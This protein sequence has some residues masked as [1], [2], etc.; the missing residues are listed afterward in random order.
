MSNAKD[1]NW[2]IAFSDKTTGI[3]SVPQCLT[4]GD[5]FGDGSNRILI[6]SLDQKLI[7]FE[8]SRIAHEIPLPDMPS[9]ICVH[10]SG[11]A[12]GGIPLI[13]VGA[14]NSILFFLNMRGYSKF[15]LPAP[16]KSKDEEEIYQ[17][18]KSGSL[19]L[20]D[21]QQELRAAKE[22]KVPLSQQTLSFIRSDIS[23]KTQYD[24]MKEQLIHFEESDCITTLSTIRINA[25]NNN[26]STRLLIGT[27]SRSLLLLDVTDSKIE[28]KWELGAPPSAIKSN[29]YMAGNSLIAVIARDRNIRL[30]SNMSDDVISIGCESLPI[31]VAISGD[32]IYVALMSKLVKIYDISGK[33]IETVAF[34]SHIISI[35]SINIETRQIQCCCVATENGELTFLDKS[36][37]FSSFKTDEGV[38][39]MFFGKIGREPNNLLTIS[40]QGGLFLRTLSRVTPTNLKKKSTTEEVPDPIPVPKKTKLFLDRCA[41]ERKNATDM[42]KEWTNSLRYLYLLA[43]N[44][45]AQIIDDVVVPTIDNISFSAKISGMGPEFL[46]NVQ[47]VNSGSDVISMVKIVLKYDSKLYSVSP[48]FVSLPPMVGGYKYVAKFSVKSIDREGKSDTINVIATSPSSTLPLCSSIVQMP[49]SQFPVE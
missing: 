38:S 45:Y 47:A 1:L 35:A 29:G 32:S 2:R 11:K 25:I 10:Y 3:V 13:A 41:E 9:S 4:S 40:K 18:L 42:H 26:Y 48:D 36:N 24:N 14:G 30:I 16:F 19:T 5:A 44:T 23:S 43:A 31:D 12:K 20:S 6:V 21:M 22:R 8:G 46:L 7:C 28:K 39:A 17:Q 27:E 37:R 33:L 15:S 49:I 34:D